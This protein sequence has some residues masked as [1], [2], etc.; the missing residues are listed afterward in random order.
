LLDSAWHEEMVVTVALVP[1]RLIVCALLTPLL[2]TVNVVCSF[3]PDDWLGVNLNITVQLAPLPSTN[4]F[5]HVPNPMLEKSPAFPP[6]IL[7]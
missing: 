3:V 4:P 2:F 7:K 6:L 1:V 5:E